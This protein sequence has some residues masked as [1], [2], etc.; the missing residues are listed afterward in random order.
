MPQPVPSSLTGVWVASSQA[1]VRSDVAPEHPE[2]ETP[3]AAGQWARVIGAGDL[4]ARATLVALYLLLTRNLLADFLKTGHF[5]G[6]LLLVSEF[7]VIVFT[8]VRRKAIAVDRSLFSRVTTAVSVIGPPLVRAI[9]GPAWLPDPITTLASAIGL[10]IVIAGKFTLG[11]SFGI[12]QANRGIVV[13]GV[14]KIVRHPIYA[15]YLLTHIAFALAHPAL[16]NIIV[17]VVGDAALIVRALREE[18]ALSA[19]A[20]YRNYCQRV[21]WHLIPGI[22]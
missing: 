19:D 1:P 18:R 6:L 17:L 4:F 20:D 16:R 22:F 2:T 12:V 3:V 10:S 21:S 8:L 11:R 15:G 14:Y 9:G 13:A 7:L 5:T